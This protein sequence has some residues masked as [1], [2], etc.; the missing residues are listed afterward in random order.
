[1]NSSVIF[2]KENYALKIYGTKPSNFTLTTYR[3]SGVEKGSRQS[4]VNMGDYLLYKAK[5]G[6]AQYSGGTAVLISESAFGNEKY[7][8]AVAGKHKNKYY[9]SLENIKG[10]NEM[11]C[12]DVQKSLWHKEDD[13][14]MLSTATY[15][16]TMYYVNDEN[17]YIVCAESE[18]NL[19]DNIMYYDTK[20]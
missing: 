2:F 6:I 20:K 5:N 7:R 3:V 19:L 16:D 13:T 11:F 4:L 15:N 9:V 8:N 1:M 17:N 14:R 10:G 12:F 18:N